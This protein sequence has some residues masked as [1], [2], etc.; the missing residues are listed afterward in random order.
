MMSKHASCLLR[1]P[2]AIL[3]FKQDILVAGTYLVRH[4]GAAAPTVTYAE[5][6]DEHA[7]SSLVHTWI[8]ATNW[9]LSIVYNVLPWLHV[10]IL[11]YQA[12]QSSANTMLRRCYRVL[13]T[14]PWSPIYK[15][16]AYPAF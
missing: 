8:I 7:L 15:Y 3:P 5:S 13:V 1:T 10:I 12:S 6:A 14:P 4:A 16:S 9:S 11:A 2:L